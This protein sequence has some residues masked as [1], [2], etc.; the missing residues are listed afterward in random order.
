MTK[1]NTEFWFCNKCKR[2]EKMDAESEEKYCQFCGEIKQVSL[3]Y[4]GAKTEPFNKW[5]TRS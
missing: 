2:G 3:Y 1:K 5:K 4:F